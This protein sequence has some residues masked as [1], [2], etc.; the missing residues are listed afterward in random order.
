[1]AAVLLTLVALGSYPESFVCFLAC[2]L[3]CLLAF[4]SDTSKTS[5][6]LKLRK[7]TSFRG[8]AIGFPAKQRLR[9]AEGKNAVM[10]T[11][12]NKFLCW[13]KAVTEL[14]GDLY[15]VA[16]HTPHIQDYP[17]QL[18]PSHTVQGRPC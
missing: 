6:R 18:P 2:L 7:Q 11:H 14:T 3:A 9:T 15:S 17:I 13:R 8:A 5:C 10:M 12:M 4:L 1:M 16:I